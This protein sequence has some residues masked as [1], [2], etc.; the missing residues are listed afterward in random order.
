MSSTPSALRLSINAS[1]ALI[2]LAMVPAGLSPASRGFGGVPAGAGVDRR[3]DHATLVA[4]DRVDHR[5]DQLLAEQGRLEAEVQ[6]LRVDRVVVV[7]LLLDP[8]VLAVPDLDRIAEVPG[9]VLDEVRQ[10]D[11]RELLGELVEDPELAGLG[12]VCRRQLH[13]VERVADVEE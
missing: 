8:R 1:A 10:V 6:Q 5:L 11:H 13:A 2:G 3:L 12:R 9:A 4:L 7:L